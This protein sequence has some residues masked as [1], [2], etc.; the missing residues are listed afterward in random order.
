MKAS[1]FGTFFPSAVSSRK[2]RPIGLPLRPSPSLILLLAGSRL[3][4]TANASAPSEPL[5][6][7]GLAAL[8]PSVLQSLRD[9]EA[10]A[11]PG[12]LREILETFRS[13]ATDKIEVMRLAAEEGDR[14]A[15]ER[16]AHSLKGSCGMVGAQRM[17]ERCRCVEA[18]AEQGTGGKKAHLDAVGEEWAYVREEIEGL[19]RSEGR[20]GSPPP[21]PPS[22]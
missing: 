13:T 12:L 14:E 16:A 2:N 1:W 7:P 5:P 17:A 4:M 15:L 10:A 18:A 19:L 20:V 9:L 8:D 22:G 6:S 3:A 11:E 21:S